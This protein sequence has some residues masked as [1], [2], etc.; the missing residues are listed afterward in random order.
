MIA[1]TVHFY[2]FWPFSVNIAGAPPT[3]SWSNRTK[4][5]A[6]DRESGLL[7]AEEV[8]RFIES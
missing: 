7:P 1:A 4:P 5:V 8:C 6:L 2:G 3:T